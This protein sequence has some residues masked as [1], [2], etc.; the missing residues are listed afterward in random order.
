ML[1][2]REREREINIYRE[3]ERER[4]KR[5]E[6]ERE[7]EKERE[8]SSSLQSGTHILNTEK[9]FSGKKKKE[10]KKKRNVRQTTISG[11]ES[12]SR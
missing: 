10:I 4:E 3:R 7:R 1:R 11:R 5:E 2:E 9:Y 12:D 8:R 6:R